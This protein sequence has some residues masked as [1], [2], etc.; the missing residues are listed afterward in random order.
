MNKSRFIV[1]LS[2]VLLLSSCG[3]LKNST[4]Q[5]RKYMDGFYVNTSH[6]AKQQ[7]ESKPKIENTSKEVPSSFAGEKTETEK[8][9]VKTVQKQSPQKIISGIVGASHQK[10]SITQ[11]IEKKIT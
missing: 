10:N 5:K 9:V 4:V 11:K 2:L 8:P 6:A 7:T 1:F 3:F